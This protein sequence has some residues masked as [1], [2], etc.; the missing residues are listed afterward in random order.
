MKL[1]IC[2]KVFE[3]LDDKEH[4]VKKNL[5]GLKEIKEIRIIEGLDV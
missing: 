4:R 2:K 3:R 5:L 1:A